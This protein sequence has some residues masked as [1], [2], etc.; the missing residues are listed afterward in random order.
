MRLLLCLSTVLLL[1][2]CLELRQTIVFEADGS[3]SQTVHMIL[4]LGT[5]AT[6]RAA[7]AAAQ[8][9]GAADPLALFS[10]ETVE[11]ELAEAG[12]KLA[13]HAPGERADV[14][15]VR[16]VASFPS[17]A[18]LRK[19]PLAGSSAE[20]TVAAG[21]VPKTVQLTLY[22][23]GATAWREARAK[24]EA[25]LEQPDP[26]AT[27]FL[28]KRKAQL[29]GLDLK[30]RL[31]LPGKV[32]RWTRNMERVE[33]CVVEATVQASDLSTPMDLVRRLAPR[34]E[35]VFAD[36]TGVFPVDR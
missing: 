3:G 9:G 21:P 36:P 27:D 26:I 16:L 20:W 17:V 18:A 15:E 4:P 33:D 23:Q 35:V 6:I 28:E 11:H 13:E 34:Y 31:Q 5:V 1:A 30:L 22:P 19:S 2:G 25:M 29:A 7:G 32:L 8:A 14:R 10:R 12:M 24:A